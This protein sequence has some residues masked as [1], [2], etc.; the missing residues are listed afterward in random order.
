MQNLVRSKTIGVTGMVE[1]V[2]QGPVLVGTFFT[3]QIW[4]QSKGLTSQGDPQTKGEGCGRLF[5]C[6]Y[7]KS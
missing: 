1:G 5:I 2:Q 7:P 3:H 4:P 6:F